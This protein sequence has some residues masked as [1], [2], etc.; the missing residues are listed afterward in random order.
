M[1]VATQNSVIGRVENCVGI[2]QVI[3]DCI[4]LTNTVQTAYNDL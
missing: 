1:D 4:P 2:Q 3:L